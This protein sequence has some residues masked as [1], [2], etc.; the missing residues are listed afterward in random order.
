MTHERPYTEAEI[1]DAMAE[2]M[3]TASVHPAF[4]HAFRVCGFLL[5]EE[6]ADQF[7]LDDINRWEEAVD[8]WF[9]MHPDAPPL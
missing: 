3:E 9:K 6:N 8:G 7:D 1:T 5:T 4:V 2:T